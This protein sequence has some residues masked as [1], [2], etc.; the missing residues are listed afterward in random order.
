MKTD[1]LVKMVAAAVAESYASSSA[2][3]AGNPNADNFSEL[4]DSMHALQY[5]RGMDVAQRSTVAL[6]LNT[7]PIA[8]WPSTLR[9]WQEEAF[10]RKL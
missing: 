2:H 4:L 1:M 3:Y 10:Q 5:W 7:V 8:D 6:R 9:K